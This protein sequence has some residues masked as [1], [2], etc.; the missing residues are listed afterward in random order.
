MDEVLVSI[1]HGNAWRHGA[2]T[3]AGP[4][5]IQATL[6]TLDSI[7]I[8]LAFGNMIQEVKPLTAVLEDGYFGMN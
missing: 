3:I 2:Q 5:D 8:D 6:L 1:I 4:A 7:K